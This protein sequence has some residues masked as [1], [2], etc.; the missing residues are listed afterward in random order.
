MR[1]RYRGKLSKETDAV[2]KVAGMPSISFE[3]IGR[4]FCV[5]R[6]YPKVAKNC[7]AEPDQ[8]HFTRAVRRAS[9]TKLGIAPPMLCRSPPLP[10]RIPT[11]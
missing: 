10:L 5:G 7:P 3:K 11:C 6:K 8:M 9:P 4:A 2:F 1:D